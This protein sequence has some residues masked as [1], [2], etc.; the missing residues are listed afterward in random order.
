MEPVRCR[1]MTS[2]P[3]LLIVQC[4]FARHLDPRHHASIMT[5]MGEVGV[6]W[7]ERTEW[8]GTA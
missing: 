5:P 2:T 3:F 7:E 4:D 6:A 1:A 8:P